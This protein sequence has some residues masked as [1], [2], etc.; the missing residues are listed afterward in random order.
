MFFTIGSPRFGVGSSSDRRTLSWTW[1]RT[2]SRGLSNC[3]FNNQ[4]S[5]AG[6]RLLPKAALPSLSAILFDARVRVK[7]KRDFGPSSYPG[8]KEEF[9]TERTEI[10]EKSTSSRE[11]GLQDYSSSFLG[12]QSLPASLLCGLWG[13]IFLVT[14]G[15]L[16]GRMIG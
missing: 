10:T 9:T 16:E 15:H 2:V 7:W 11:Q 3:R 8:A 4:Q 14:V 5:K 6:L 12:S 13:E 1:R